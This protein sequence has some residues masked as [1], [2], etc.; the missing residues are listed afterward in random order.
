MASFEVTRQLRRGDLI[1]SA[2]TILVVIKWSKTLQNRS[3]TTTSCIPALGRFPLCPF[4]AMSLMLH[5]IPGTAN[6]PL[7]RIPRASGLAPLTDFVARKHLKLVSQLL[8][9]PPR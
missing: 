3:D 8:N 6:D 2:D 1:F 7:F 4:K 9:L 5:A